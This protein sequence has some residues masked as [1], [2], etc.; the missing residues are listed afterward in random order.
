[1]AR[2]VRERETPRARHEPR[3]AY[4]QGDGQGMKYGGMGVWET[5]RTIFLQHIRLHPRVR[6]K[7]IQRIQD[8]QSRTIL[9]RKDVVKLDRELAYRLCK[10]S[11]A[12]V[13]VKRPRAQ[14][15]E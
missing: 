4:E 12:K 8:D 1:M 10:A 3:G 11:N 2:R 7:M 14:R 9:A 5:V 15:L 13:H 6:E